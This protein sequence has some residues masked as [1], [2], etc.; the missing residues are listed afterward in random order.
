[1]VFLRAEIPAAHP[2]A[3]VL[4]EERMGAGVA[5]TPEHVLTAHYLVLGAATA[6]VAGIDG[7]SRTVDRVSLDHESGLAL[8]TVEGPGLE[9]ARLGGEEELRPGDP[10][11]VVTCTGD[12]E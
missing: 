5:V 10:V 3:A 12:R 2:S 6:E 11:F 4:G 7:R 9:P 8:L 1:M